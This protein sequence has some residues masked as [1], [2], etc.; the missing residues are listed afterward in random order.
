MSEYY[1]FVV[2]DKGI[3]EA[4][5]CDCPKT[6]LRRKNKPDGSWLTKIGIKYPGAISFWTKPGLKKYLQSGLMGWHKSVVKG[7]VK[8]II[9]E[10][11]KNILFRDQDQIIVN[12]KDIQIKKTISLKDFFKTKIAIFKTIEC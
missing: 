12:P 7:E 10:E 9:I 3:Y 5:E 1:R 6:D 8:I 4:V 11:P 2:N